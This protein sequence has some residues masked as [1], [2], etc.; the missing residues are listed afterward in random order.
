MPGA[1]ALLS[2]SSA[3]R[4]MV[5]TAAPLYEMNFPPSVSQFAQEGTVAHS[6][7]ELYVR[8]MIGQMDDR[9]FDAQLKLLQRNEL[10]AAEMLE[11]AQFYAAYIDRR[12]K[13]L[14]PADPDSVFVT[15][16]DKVVLDRWVKGGFGTCD[17]V[18]FGDSTLQIVDYK[19]GKGVEVSAVGNPQMRLYAL[20]ALAKYQIIF[21]DAIQTVSMSIVQPRITEDVSTDTLSVADLLAWG[22]TAKAKAEEALSG[23]GVFAPGVEQ[24]KFCRGKAVCRARAEQAAE[25]ERQ[26]QG[27][28]PDQLSDTEVGLFLDLGEFLSSWYEELQDYA[29]QACVQGRDI[30]GYKAVEGRSVRAFTDSDKAFEVLRKEGYDDAVLYDQVPKSLA[31]LEKLVGKKAFS[32]LMVGLIT[33]PRGKPTLAKA[34]DKRKPFNQAVADFGDLKDNPPEQAAEISQS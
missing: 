19:H 23:N 2:P 17:C 27:R 22:E 9:S 16:E 34:G 1:H 18:M 7:C 32:S 5:C 26:I 28:K 12:A 15:V 29:L 10:Y 20:G 3:H 4:W 31:A 11:T 30:T 14:N 6:V 24:C 21:G 8:H 25:L 13:E 33:K